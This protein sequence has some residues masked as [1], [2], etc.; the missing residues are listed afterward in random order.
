MFALVTS[1][2]DVEEYPAL[3][4]ACCYPERWGAATTV[5]R[6]PQ[7]NG[8]WARASPSCGREDP[9]GRQMP[10]NVGAVR[11]ATRAICR[12]IGNRRQTP[13]GIPPPTGSA[14][15]PAHALAARD[16]DTVPRL[17]PP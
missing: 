8:T 11:R 7:Q 9:E 6:P 14:L 17:F 10:G 5:I 16:P 2:L 12:I 4:L 15:S 1:L 3:D 13:A